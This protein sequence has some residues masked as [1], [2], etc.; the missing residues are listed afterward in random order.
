MAANLKKGLIL[1]EQKVFALFTICD[2]QVS[3][4]KLTFEYLTF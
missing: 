2:D 3:N 4:E 1:E